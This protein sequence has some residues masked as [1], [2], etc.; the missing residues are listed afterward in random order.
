[1]INVVPYDKEWTVRFLELQRVLGDALRGIQV[2]S[3]EHVGS[4]SVPGLAAKPI[5]DID[6]VVSEEDV[7]AA[8]EAL[9]RL[10]FVSRGDLGIPDRYAFFAPKS[11]FP[12]HTYVVV[13]GCLALRNH[14]A[15]RDRL[16]SDETLRNEYGALKSRLAESARDIEQY[17][18]QKSPIL[19]RIPARA[20]MTANEL[21]KIEHV[22]KA[23]RC[24][25]HPGAGSP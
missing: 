20:G 7:V 18:E 15:V 3:I 1:M 2:V 4:T 14:V 13:D 5:I 12:T 11:F 19:Q 9:T 16:R 10:G 23:T 8:S 21:L 6:V 25:G 22:D 24:Q 17:V